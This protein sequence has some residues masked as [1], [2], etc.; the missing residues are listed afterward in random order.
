MCLRN[1]TQIVRLPE[2]IS[3]QRQRRVMRFRLLPSEYPNLPEAEAMATRLDGLGSTCRRRP[4]RSVTE[5][6]P[7]LTLSTETPR[8]LSIDAR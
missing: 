2:G 1:H 3:A 5:S 4:R 7:R 8:T 6:D